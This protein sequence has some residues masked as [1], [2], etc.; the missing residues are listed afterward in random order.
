LRKRNRIPRRFR[1]RVDNERVAG[2]QHASSA[3]PRHAHMRDTV[4][5]WFD[6]PTPHVTFITRGTIHNRDEGDI[7]NHAFVFELK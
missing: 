7:A 6:G 4:L 1:A 3:A 2:W 5:V